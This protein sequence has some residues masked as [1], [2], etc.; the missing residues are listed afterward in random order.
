MSSRSHRHLLWG[1]ILSLCAVWPANAQPIELT[2]EERIAEESAAEARKYGDQLFPPQRGAKKTDCFDPSVALTVEEQRL[3]RAIG[4]NPE[5]VADQLLRRSGFDRF[6]APFA[7]AL[8]TAPNYQVAETIMVT[9]GKELWR[10]AVDRVQGRGPEGGD[11]PRSDDRPLFWA[12]LQMTRAL[13]QWTPR[14]PLT[15]TQREQLEWTLERASRGHLDID[16]PVGEGMK[17]MLITGF[18]PFGLDGSQGRAIRNGNPSGAI[19]LALDGTALLTPTGVAFVEVAMFPVRWRDFVL[20]MVEDAV[21][22]YMQEGPRRIHASMTISQGGSRM[23]IEAWNGRYHTGTDNNLTNP[24]PQD[25]TDDV[26]APS[27]LITPPTPWVP[28]EAPQWTWTTQPHA[29]M[30]AA[31]TQ[32]FTTF[33]R[34]SVRE[35]ISCTSRETVSLP[36]GPSSLESC[37]RAGGGGSFLSNEIAYRVTLLRDRFDLSIPAGHLHVPVMTVFAPENLYDITDS[38][39]E[40]RRDT[41]VAQVVDLVGVAAS[42][43][44]P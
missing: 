33:L 18:D 41:I 35:F 27:C 2:E 25:A 32:P 43:V 31:G 19:I 21:A 44:E 37:A 11:L 6:L 26:H 7:V 10:A 15:A 40:E 12:R 36:D 14:F 8:C 20:G 17:R 42:T 3:T 13:K 4:P 24:C 30:I 9:H 16:F 5:P 29:S 22:P 28:Y 1:S 23:D 39:L 34:T 38:M